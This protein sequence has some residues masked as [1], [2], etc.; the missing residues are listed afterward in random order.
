MIKKKRFIINNGYIYSA[1]VELFIV[2]FLCVYFLCSST[3]GRI[4]NT[5]QLT[6]GPNKLECYIAVCWKGLPET[7]T[8]AY[9][10]HS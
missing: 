10:A 3:W 8:L 4:H 1:L 6:N 2:T 9:W 5:S 7:N